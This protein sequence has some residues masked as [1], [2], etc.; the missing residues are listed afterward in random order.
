MMNWEYQMN[1]LEPVCFWKT[2][3]TSSRRLW[4]FSKPVWQ[5]PALGWHE[6]WE[7]EKWQRGRRCKGPEEEYQAVRAVTEEKM[8]LMVSSSGRTGEHGN[9]NRLDM[10]W[11]ETSQ[12]C[13][14]FGRKPGLTQ[15]PLTELQPHGPALRLVLYLAVTENC[16]HTIE[17]GHCQGGKFFILGFPELIFRHEGA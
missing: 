2:G 4:H 14:L 8:E 6:G 17:M 11:G 7:A 15:T 5:G 9:K 1:P 16:Y 3:V 12:R 10:L 13:K